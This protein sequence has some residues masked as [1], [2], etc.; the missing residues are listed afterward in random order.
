MAGGA[1]CRPTPGVA[2]RPGRGTV[3]LRQ[4]VRLAA[5]GTRELTMRKATDTTLRSLAI[6]QAIPAYPRT[7]STRRIMEELRDLDPDFDVTARSFQR[8][9]DKLSAMF[10]IACEARG[11]AN[12]WY[13]IDEHALTQI[14]AMSAPTAF[15]LRMVAEYLGPLMPPTVL[16]QL[17]AYSGTPTESSRTRRSGGGATGRRSSSAGPCCSRRRFTR[18][19][20]R[21]CTRA[22]SWAGA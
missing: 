19:S 6:L 18:T 9:L 7:K 17:D 21:P 15:V 5:A 4:A 3:E 1:G 8:S 2:C 14:P 20:R 10:P 11:R 13:W 12:H 22:C 16:R